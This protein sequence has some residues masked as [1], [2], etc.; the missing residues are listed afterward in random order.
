VTIDLAKSTTT[1]KPV[2]ATVSPGD[3]ISASVTY[4]GNNQFVLTIAD[5]TQNWTFTTKQ[6][7]NAV[8]KR[9]SAEWIVEAPA[10]SSGILPL[11]DF[12][13]V[14]F[15]GASTTIDGQ[16][17]PIDGTFPSSANAQVYSINMVSH[18][19]TEA[20]TSTLTDSGSP[21]TSAFTV[22]YTAATTASPASPSGHHH[23]WVGW[24]DYGFNSTNASSQTQDS[25]QIDSKSSINARDAFFASLAARG[26]V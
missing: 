19:I 25:S 21:S 14:P 4:T 8:F 3:S 24:G 18:S 7:L 15:T 26:V 1:G 2:L 5:A 13:S 22:T 12:G 17:G 6:A 10:A 20:T 23:G 9:S 16:T 11:A